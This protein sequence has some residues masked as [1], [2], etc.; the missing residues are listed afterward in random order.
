MP[1]TLGDA[2]VQFRRKD[3]EA[4]AELVD[5]LGRDGTLRQRLVARQ[6]ERVKEFL[7]PQVRQRWQN[8]LGEVIS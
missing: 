3:Y 6:R 7:V 2:G 8:F 1:E 5:I 4:L